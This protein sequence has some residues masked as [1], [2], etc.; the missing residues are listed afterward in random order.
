MINFG[1]IRTTIKKTHIMPKKLLI[2]GK[3]PPPIG[4]VTIHVQRLIDT[5]EKNNI[6]FQFR[7]LSKRSIF[8]LLL[9]TLVKKQII[10]LHAS[11]PN[12]RFIFAF[13]CSISKS[14]LIVTYHGNI[15]R[16]NNIRNWFDKLSIKLS[17]IPVV[18]NEESHKLAQIINSETLLIPAFIP[19]VQ[20][21]ILPLHIQNNLKQLKSKCTTIF[22]T[23]AYRLSYD[24]EGNEIYCGSLLKKLFSLEANQQ[25][26]FVFSDPSGSYKQ[27]L[28]R[29][30]VK[31]S[32]NILFISEPH[33]FFE[34]LKLSDCF[35]RATTTDGDPL[36]VKEALFL[37]KKVLASDV[38]KRPPGC[39]TFNLKDIDDLQKMV[40]QISQHPESIS[41]EPVIN[42][43]NNLIQLYNKINLS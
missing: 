33:S 31:L 5:L 6:N 9:L 27:F 3:T 40:H 36:S 25:Y 32:E 13:L 17:Y 12:I 23:N 28:E 21:D 30:N 15:G 7:Q 10:H 26:G 4:G 35:I 18:L 22:C 39:M 14:R 38:I 16:F 20:K 24:K 29:K 42:G 2:I 43:A 37:E 11:S 1:R 8:S 34:V 41:K 19:P